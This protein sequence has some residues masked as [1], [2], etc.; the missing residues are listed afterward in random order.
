MLRHLARLGVRLG[1]ARFAFG[2]GGGL[3]R[4]RMGSVLSRGLEVRGFVQVL[5]GELGRL[6]GWLLG[7]SP[8]AEK[9]GPVWCIERRG[10]VRKA[11]ESR[12][13]GE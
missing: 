13:F 12:T 11:K 8:W 4:R 9:R 1:V 7:R 5:R 2:G 6:R 3:A 10:E